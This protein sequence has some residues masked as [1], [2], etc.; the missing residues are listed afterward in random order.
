MCSSPSLTT[1][2]VPRL[3]PKTGEC[4]PPFAS[5]EEACLAC[6]TATT[7]P[8]DPSVNVTRSATDLWDPEHPGHGAA[9]LRQ[10]DRLVGVL[11]FER[12][13]QA[14][15]QLFDGDRLHLV[16]RLQAAPA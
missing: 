9:A 16:P 10:R 5:S 1:V 11:L 7:C 3:A 13:G 6:T 14:A 12:L 15:T 4:A 8:P 2:R